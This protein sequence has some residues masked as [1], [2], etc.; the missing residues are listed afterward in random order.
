M[1]QDSQRQRIE[2][3]QA[4]MLEQEASKRRV[5]DFVRQSRPGYATDD[6]AADSEK[7]LAADGW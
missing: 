2:A 5:A 1:V 6:A 3:A 4:D 7:R